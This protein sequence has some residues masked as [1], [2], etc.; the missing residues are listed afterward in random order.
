MFGISATVRDELKQAKMNDNT[1]VN[2]DKGIPYPSR[3][4]ARRFP[5]EDMEVGDS[6]VAELKDKALIY[7]H[8]K[9]HSPK[10]FITRTI[11]EDKQAMLRIWRVI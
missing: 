3:R 10:R 7:Y 6:F 5:F 8:M 2:I 1:K 11:R 9:L 4:E